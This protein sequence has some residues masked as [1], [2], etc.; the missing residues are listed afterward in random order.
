M[1]VSY[2]PSYAQFVDNYLATYYSG[3]VGTLRRVAGG[4]MAIVAGALIIIAS[5][6]WL[7]PGFF[8]SLLVVAASF[9]ILGGLFYAARPLIN[10]LLVGLRREKF[11]GEETGP[12]I[13]ELHEDRL[14]IT[15]NK[16]VLELP[17][18]QIKS[19]QHRADSTWILTSGDY[20]ISVPRS[21]LLEGDHD[22]FV[23]ALE[24]LLAPDEEE[25]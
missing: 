18:E 2:R 14:Q 8:R 3:G 7:A 9:L 23:S 11:F 15:E 17:I 12:T 24:A 6:S 4:P 25:E 1:R 10:I 22:K 5:I 13:I 21:G 16:E 19:I 20:L